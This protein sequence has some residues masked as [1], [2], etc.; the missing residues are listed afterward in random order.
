MSWSHT[1]LCSKDCVF[2][3]FHLP[4]S[5]T[6][7]EET[8]VTAHLGQSHCIP[9]HDN[10]FFFTVCI[11]VI[12]FQNCRNSIALL[13][14]SSTSYYASWWNNNSLHNKKFLPLT[15][16]CNVSDTTEAKG[17]F[18]TNLKMKTWLSTPLIGSRVNLTWPCDCRFQL[19]KRRS[20]YW[21]TL[22]VIFPFI[23]RTSIVT[24]ET[25]FSLSF[26]PHS[27]LRKSPV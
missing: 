15:I 10:T 23:S 25:S 12:S 19:P 1:L 22:G 4:I 11:E 21:G 5:Y 16:N 27:T 18:G 8:V 7:N 17:L 3:H 6:V 20:L 2:M 9:F 24:S 26:V 14:L 13:A